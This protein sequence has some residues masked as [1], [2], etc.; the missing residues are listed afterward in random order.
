MAM[1]LPNPPQGLAS[2]LWHGL[3]VRNIL[4]PITFFLTFVITLS[5]ASLARRL[6][7]LQC[8]PLL[9]VNFQLP[10]SG[11]SALRNH[12]SWYGGH[13]WISAPLSSCS[14]FAG[15][16]GPNVSLM[17]I[18]HFRPCIFRVN[19]SFSCGP[20]LSL[21]WICCFQVLDDAGQVV[22]EE[23]RVSF[24]SLLWQQS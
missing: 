1:A 15:D 17:W 14:T 3:Q 8:F 24:S 16:C 23:G 9:Y 13:L 21:M 10:L 22:I 18:C 4:G 5:Q 6:I 12:E 2:E 19:L 20:K 7:I 11:C